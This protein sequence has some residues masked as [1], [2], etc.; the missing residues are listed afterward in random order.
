MNINEPLITSE[1]SQNWNLLGELELQAEASTH[2]LVQTWLR[3]ISN[4][5][6]L[7]VGLLDRIFTSI[8]D[9][10][11]RAHKHDMAIKSKYVHIA[12][13]GPGN[14]VPEGKTWGYFHT[15]KI[16]S[17]E[18]DDTILDH[19]IDFYLYAEGE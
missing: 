1:S 3:E 13:F 10:K 18:N 19:K 14:L 12:I 11:S 6:N 9:S 17:R 8:Q 15:E 2:I 16:S 5:L 7:P 4:P